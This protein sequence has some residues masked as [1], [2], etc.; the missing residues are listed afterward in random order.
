[1]NAINYNVKLGRSSLQVDCNKGE[2]ESKYQIDIVWYTFRSIKLEQVNKKK[3]EWDSRT[4][5]SFTS[6]RWEP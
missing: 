6:Q 1:M 3:E 5:G 2:N 4:V